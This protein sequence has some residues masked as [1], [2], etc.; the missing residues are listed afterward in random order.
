[1]IGILDMRLS[2]M[3]IKL[4]FLTRWPCQVLNSRDEVVTSVKSVVMGELS[5][6]G[7]AAAP[8]YRVRSDGYT[9]FI[10]YIY[11]YIYVYIYVNISI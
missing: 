4:Q 1:M 5:K 8:G 9:F 2:Y 11:T 6:L 3:H 10:L 7:D